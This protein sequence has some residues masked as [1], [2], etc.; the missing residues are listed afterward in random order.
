MGSGALVLVCPSH[1]IFIFGKTHSKT[2][3]SFTIMENNNAL[4]PPPIPSKKKVIGTLKLVV[5]TF[6][7][8]IYLFIFLF[9]SEIVKFIYLVLSTIFVR[10]FFSI[11]IYHFKPAYCLFSPKMNRGKRIHIC[12]KRHIQILE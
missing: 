9:W 10:F 3:E 4:V 1:L 6:F 8:P 2:L 12:K 11:F 5:M 7:W